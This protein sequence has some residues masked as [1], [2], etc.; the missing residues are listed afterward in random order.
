LPDDERVVVRRVS[1]ERNDDAVREGALRLDQGDTT[2]EA[3]GEGEDEE[4]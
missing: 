2:D 1:H 4:T 3:D